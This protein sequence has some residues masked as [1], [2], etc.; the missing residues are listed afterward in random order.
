M[1]QHIINLCEYIITKLDP[2]R[3]EQ[4][5]LST[6]EVSMSLKG[7]LR[8]NKWV[9]VSFTVRAWLKNCD[10]KKSSIAEVSINVD[11][12]KK[13]KKLL[14]LGLQEGIGSSIKE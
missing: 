12:A 10:D 6:D 5:R 3:I 14:S 8:K 4:C 11:G 7:Y 13:K 9:N 1:K 2:I